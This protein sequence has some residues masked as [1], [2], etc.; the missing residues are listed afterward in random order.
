MIPYLYRSFSQKLPI[1]SGS[2]VE[3]DM[4]LR[5]SYESSPPCT[6]W[7]KIIFPIHVCV[8]VRV[9]LRVCMFPGVY[10]VASVGVCLC[11]S[12]HA[13]LNMCVR[14]FLRAYVCFCFQVALS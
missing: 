10:V 4:Q 11:I 14:V 1:F 6:S 13:H 3:N 7:M 8:R 2:F 5:G 12:M 9:G